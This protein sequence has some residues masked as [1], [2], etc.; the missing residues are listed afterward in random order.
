[1]AQKAPVSALD[2]NVPAAASDD[3][4]VRNRFA[5]ADEALAAGLTDTAAGLYEVLSKDFQHIAPLYERARLGLA[6]CRLERNNPTGA[7]EVLGPLPES[8]S[9]QIR[10]AIA[11]TILGVRL[12]PGESLNT[13]NPASLSATD[14]P[15]YHIAR[16]L[17]A[18]AT[19]TLDSFQT[20]QA[21]F[22]SAR[23]QYADKAQHYQEQHVRML[24]YLARLKIG[25]PSAQELDKL[26]EQL[27]ESMTGHDNDP[28][29]FKFAKELAIALYKRDRA[30][31]AVHI[32][33]QRSYMPANERDETDLLIG[34]ILAPADN[35]GKADIRQSPESRLALYR[36]LANKADPELQ[37]LALHK[38][39][40][41]VG[42]LP[43]STDN[44]A[45][46]I[47][48]TLTDL[49]NAAPD[50]RTIDLLNLVRARI[51]FTVRAYSQAERAANDLLERPGSELRADALRILASAAWQ[52]GAT[53]RAAEH[54]TQLQSLMTGHDQVRTAL[55]A[56]DC[57]FLAAQGPSGDPTAYPLAAAAYAAIQPRLPT[58]G[59]RSNTL[60][61]RIQCELLAG[62][63]DNAARILATATADGAEGVGAPGILRCEWA[64]VEWLRT[65]N[66]ANE[67]AE[68]LARVFERHRADMDADFSIRFLWQQALFAYTSGDT[69]KAALLADQIAGAVEKLPPTTPSD[70]LSQ[71]QTILSKVSLLKA[72][73]VLASDPGA[74]RT[75]FDELRKKFP[76]EE[77][78][79]ASYLVEGRSLAAHG[80][81]ERALTIFLDACQFYPRQSAQ[82]FADYGAEALFEA[83]QQYIAIGKNNGL[84]QTVDPAGEKATGKSRATYQSTG[85]TPVVLAIE[86]LK[87]FATDYP[88]HKLAGTARLQ[89]AALFRIATDYDDAL[90][91][92]DQLRSELPD[93]TAARWQAELGRADCL[94][95]KAMLG[96]VMHSASATPGGTP[97][98]APRTAVTPAI[99]NTAFGPAVA[100]YVGLFN[101]PSAPPD[102]KAE[103]GCKW[104]FAL[105]ARHPD[106]QGSGLTQDNI[107][108]E[109]DEARW[110]VIF[111][112]IKDASAS[113][114]L[115]PNGRYWVARALMELAASCKM[116]GLTDDA[117]KAYSLL[118]EYNR[119]VQNTPERVLPGQNSAKAELARLTRETTPT[120]NAATR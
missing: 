87:K 43:E 4:R 29:G 98:G 73:A 36:V 65:H 107:A 13:I 100:A 112:T 97:P 9:R 64:L 19:D 46:E 61:L 69:T 83:A 51:M 67:A 54:L 115:G 99:V 33:R 48:K 91:I 110:Q 71:T 3:P 114:R 101:L 28:L 49:A 30:A 17:I 37:R 34:F 59:E 53:R 56:A 120:A 92:Y 106:P 81:H 38:L 50:P 52:T 8:P 22:A 58:P 75:I 31:E 60:F 74:A 117:A 24:D 62:N 6:S 109:A 103:A 108:R 78:V 32:L 55:I 86:T 10:L 80:E 102:L 40:D 39:A 93:N 45:P 118:L 41:A 88:N 1:M 23:A 35:P 72:R 116:R 42:R 113:T 21:E 5:A 16:G 111:R 47:Y 20:A 68:R 11:H 70:L 79:A 96:A 119:E 14:I 66:R 94:F 90:F 95:A 25:N 63:G 27:R 105:A 84:D 104:S 12:G 44:P 26:I 2:S 15:W 7:I 89:Q 18:V 82:P 57:F 77:A 76:T 85:K